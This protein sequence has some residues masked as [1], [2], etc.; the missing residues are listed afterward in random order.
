MIG[1]DIRFQA[2]LLSQMN[3]D[4][5]GLCRSDQQALAKF[6]RMNEAFLLAV[7]HDDPI[8]SLVRVHIAADAD[9]PAFL[10]PSGPVPAGAA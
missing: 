5:A 3:A 2:L 10:C 7:A 8:S 9:I 6:F 1:P 4:R